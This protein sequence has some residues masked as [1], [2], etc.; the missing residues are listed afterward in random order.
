V[1]VIDAEGNEA[2]EVELEM[3]LHNSGMAVITV[4]N[5]DFSGS[6]PHID[7]GST[8]DLQGNVTD[9]VDIQTIVIIIEEEDSHGK[10]KTGELVEIEIDLSGSTVTFFDFADL[11]G[12]GKAIEIPANAPDGDYHFLIIV[13]DSDGNMTIWEEEI[14][15]D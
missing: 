7:K 4:T 2:E 12:M 10:V 1:Q 5:P 8:M 14:H 15:I 6:H 11:P 13:T 3:M 9:D